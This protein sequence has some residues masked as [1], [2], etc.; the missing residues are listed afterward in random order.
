MLF[1]AEPLARRGKARW[2]KEE[3]VLEVSA[4][5]PARHLPGANLGA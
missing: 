2:A 4:G 1:S 3:S 5:H